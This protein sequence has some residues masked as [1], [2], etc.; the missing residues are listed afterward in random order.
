MPI[1][2]C[3][4]AA[5]M[6]HELN[7]AGRSF[8]IFIQ[9]GSQCFIN[10]RRVFWLASRPLARNKEM[11]IQK[12]STYIL[13]GAMDYTFHY[14]RHMLSLSKLSFTRP[15]DRWLA[16]AGV[17]KLRPAGGPRAPPGPP[18]PPPRPLCKITLLKKQ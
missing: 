16:K 6:Q 8:H 1:L 7:C 3:W 14:I 11:G 10:E 18:P 5:I 15:K 17:F 2:P 12:H 13:N 9:S 4:V